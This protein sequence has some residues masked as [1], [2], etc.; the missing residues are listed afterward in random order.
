MDKFFENMNTPGHGHVVDANDNQVFTGTKA[1][2][3]KFLAWRGRF[4]E[5]EEKPVCA[6]CG[7]EIDKFYMN[8]AKNPFCSKSHRTTFNR[9][10]KK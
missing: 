7:G 5:P 10:R 4:D 3:D 9:E 6:Y 8:K 2:C 1:E